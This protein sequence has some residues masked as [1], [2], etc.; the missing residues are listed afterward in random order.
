V[1][2]VR[3]LH[4][5]AMRLVEKAMVQRAQRK[6][7][8]A[9]ELVREAYVY[10]AQAA[11]LIP[12]EEA[13]EPTRSILYRSAGW[14]ALESGELEEARC[15]AEEGLAGSPP[16]D[17]AGELRHLLEAAS[18]KRLFKTKFY[19]VDLETRI[20]YGGLPF[21]GFCEAV[22]S[23]EAKSLSKRTA[24]KG[25]R[26]ITNSHVWVATGLKPTREAGNGV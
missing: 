6:H 1:S 2:T 18:L 19:L 10:E 11:G 20:V 9:S 3:E 14:L 21:K 5:K 22:D 16:G 8:L 23:K 4:D 24:L 26:V 12:K 25:S 15:L 13:S 7:R 17:I